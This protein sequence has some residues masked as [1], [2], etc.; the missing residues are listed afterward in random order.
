MGLKDLLAG[1]QG[2]TSNE[3]GTKALEVVSGVW[4]LG[5]QVQAQKA[6]ERAPHKDAKLGDEEKLRHLVDEALQTISVKAGFE[7]TANQ[8]S[9]AY[10]IA[11][12]M[13]GSKPLN[14]LLSGEVGAGKTIEIGRAHV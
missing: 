6:N 7:P 10:E 14:G 1:V 3:M 11:A 2:H 8:R 4:A 12:C 13:A 9:V 5:N